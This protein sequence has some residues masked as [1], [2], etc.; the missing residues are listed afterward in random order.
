MQTADGAAMKMSWEMQERE[1]ASHFFYND[2]N[3]TNR[4]A[5]D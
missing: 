3:T 2:N 5:N 1:Q 4:C